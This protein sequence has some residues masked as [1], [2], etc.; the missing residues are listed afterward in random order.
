MKPEIAPSVHQ[1]IVERK[2]V[3][4]IVSNEVTIGTSCKNSGCSQ[5]YDGPQT[6]EMTCLYHPGVPIFHEGL[7]FWSCCQKKTT[8]FNTFLSQIGCEKGKHTWKKDV[9][10]LSVFVFDEI[11]VFL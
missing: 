2:S 5:T 11:S 8:D 9:G 7:K 3:N 1:V 6:N 4:T 10:L